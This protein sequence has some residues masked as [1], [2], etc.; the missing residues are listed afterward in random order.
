MVEK[1]F[2]SAAGKFLTTIQGR[3]N[4]DKKQWFRTDK[5]V[6]AKC[7]S[8][9]KITHIHSEEIIKEVIIIK[10]VTSWKRGMSEKVKKKFSES[11]RTKNNI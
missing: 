6:H 1:M 8:S 7:S 2:L 9:I 5:S 11:V 4:M 3:E 10:I